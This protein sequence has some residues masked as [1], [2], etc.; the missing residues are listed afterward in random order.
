MSC[1]CRKDGVAGAFNVGGVPN[2][3]YHVVYRVPRLCV[4]ALGRQNNTA[5]RNVESLDGL[6][7]S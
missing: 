4:D 3:S 6:K 2:L 1:S 7:V 5:E